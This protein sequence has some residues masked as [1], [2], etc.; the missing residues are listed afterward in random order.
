MS[1]RVDGIAR[2]GTVAVQMENL[3]NEQK[4][5]TPVL[6]GAEETQERVS[7]ETVEKV[8][9]NQLEQI[10]A[11]QREEAAEMEEEKEAEESHSDTVV[12]I[13]NEKPQELSEKE[14]QELSLLDREQIVGRLEQLLSKGELEGAKNMVA[15]LRLK[16][17]E[18]TGEI[19]KAALDKFLAEGGN[20]I[21]FRFS[22]ALEDR[23]VSVSQKIKDYLSRCTGIRGL[24]AARRAIER[25]RDDAW[26]AM[27]AIVAL[28][29]VR[30]QNEGGYGIGELVLNERENAPGELKRRGV[31]G[32]RVPDIGLANLPV[33]FNY[34]GRGHLDLGSIPVETQSA[35][36]IKVALAEVRG[37]YVDDLRRNR[38]L[39]AGG[40]IVMPIVAEDLMEYGGLD[41]VVL[42]AV[43]A[44]ERLT[45]RSGEE[46]A[47]VRRALD[48]R[49]SAKRQQLIWSLYPWTGGQSLGDY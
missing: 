36:E 8:N 18:K 1:E 38:E 15:L 3:M 41:T 34:D 23:F 31:R 32:S 30:P 2:S 19:K 10:A 20:K 43:L 24:G 45:G 6:S 22:D 42:E 17:K 4:N 33:G 11:Q 9:L 48:K 5:Q 7:S 14:I 39:L 16:Y 13:G 25:V 21:D 12:S 35:A 28:L 40:R 29:L 27:E 26:S 47:R 46:G 49:L 37:K 44:A